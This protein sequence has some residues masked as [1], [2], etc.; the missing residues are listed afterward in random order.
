M[1]APEGKV[2]QFM[3]VEVE[4]NELFNLICL[5]KLIEESGNFLY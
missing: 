3:I 4:C 2:I 5:K 1:E